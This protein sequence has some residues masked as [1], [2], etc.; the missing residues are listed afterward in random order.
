MLLLSFSSL[1]G[2]FA[3]SIS[4]AQLSFILYASFRFHFDHI[5]YMVC[6][7]CVLFSTNIYCCY[8]EYM[9]GLQSVVTSSVIA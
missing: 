8:N 3:P 9:D 5:L 1:L 2:L 4:V 7:S 6:L